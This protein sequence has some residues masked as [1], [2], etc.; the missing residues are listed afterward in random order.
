M[1]LKLF[2]INSTNSHESA[3]FIY[4]KRK[5]W[6]FHPTADMLVTGEKKSVCKILQ[7][8]PSRCSWS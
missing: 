8:F 6:N 4:T 1:V 5:F 7:M 2:L 3:I